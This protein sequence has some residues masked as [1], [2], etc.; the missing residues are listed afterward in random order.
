LG[1]TGGATNPM[2]VPVA[3]AKWVARSVIGRDAV[4]SN[5]HRT[6]PSQAVLAAV[7]GEH[8]AVLRHG[9]RCAGLFCFGG[10]A[11]GQDDPEVETYELAR[12]WVLK[13]VDEDD[14]IED[15]CEVGSWDTLLGMFFVDELFW[16]KLSPP[17]SRQD[18][19][20]AIAGIQEGCVQLS[21][22]M[23]DQG[24]QDT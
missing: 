16:T 13:T 9:M 24:D 12:H 11:R 6:W 1:R 23:Q 7:P 20:E 2:N 4:V 14:I 10:R 21:A 3:I 8:Q 5:R 22:A 17:W 15:L 18:D 19:E